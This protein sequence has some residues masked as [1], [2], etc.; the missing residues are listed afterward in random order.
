M[1]TLPLTD[2]LAPLQAPAEAG[3]LHPVTSPLEPGVTLVEASAGTGKTFS[4]VFILVRLLLEKR[5]ESVDRALVVTFTNAATDELVTRVRAGLRS[6]AQAYAGDLE[7]TGENQIWFDLCARYPDGRP[8]VETALASIDG[9]SVF[10]IHGFCKRV[11]EENAV[12]SGTPYGAAFVEDAHDLLECAALDWW[13]RTFYDDERLACLAVA[14]GWTPS[15]WLELF[16]RWRM[17]PET[18]IDPAPPS[19][20]AACDALDEVCAEVRAAW[21]EQRLAALL[22][23]VKWNKTAPLGSEPIEGMSAA[24]EALG[25]GELEAVGVLG[26]CT[27]GALREVGNK[28]KAESKEALAKLPGD[29]FCTACERIAPA[30]EQVRRALVGDFL[31]V[32][33]DEFEQE[34][35]RRQALGFDDLLRRLH[36]RITLEGAQGALAG[37]IRSRY[38]AAL[39]D[40]FQDTDPF[41]F[42]IFSIAFRDRPLFL[43]GDPKQAIYGFRGADIF[44]YADAVRQAQRRYTLPQNWRSTTGLVG[45][46]NRI[47]GRAPRGFLRHDDE[48]RF[49]NATAARP[50]P[51]P[52]GDGGEPLQWW[53]VP[54]DGDRKCG[55]GVARERLRSRTAAE[56]VALL[57]GCELTENGSTRPVRPADIA[58]LVRTHRE[59]AAMQQELQAARVPSIVAGMGD[60]L[61]S[62]ELCELERVLKAIALPLDGDA[63]RSALATELW[64]R[65]AE[66]IRALLED[67]GESEWTALADRLAAD[68]EDWV[69]R[70]FM[71]MVQRWM[72]RERVPERML[73]L[74][75]GDRRMTNLR[76]A[77]ELLHTAS[78]TERLSPDG[79]LAWIVRERAVK[80]TEANRRELR[81]ES[82]AEAVQIVTVHR[83]KG[84]EYGITFCLSLWDPKGGDDEDVL[85][86][87]GHGVVL[88]L[89]GDSWDERARRAESERTAEELRLA[90]VALTRAKWR[91]YVG[92]GFVTDAERSPLAWLLRAEAKETATTCE[93]LLDA[94]RAGLGEGGAWLERMTRLVESEPKLM[95]CEVLHGLSAPARWNP[96]ERARGAPPAAR[97]F[98]AGAQLVRLGMASFTSLTRRDA[99][100]EG[101]DIADPPGQAA[102]DTSAGPP[103]GI[104][105]LLKGR[106]TGDLLHAVFEHADHDAPRGAAARELVESLIRRDPG[107]AGLLTQ[108]DAADAIVEM[109]ARVTAAPLPGAGF[110]LADVP[111]G[112]T[113]REWPFMLPLAPVTGRTLA[114]AFAEHAATPALREY[115]KRLER[116]SPREVRGYLTGFVDFAFTRDGRWYLLD[117]KSNHL[118]N[119]AAQY[120]DGR[121]LAEMLDHH[122]VLQYHLYVLALHRYL[123][124]RVPGYSYARD[125]GGV[126]Y[127][128]VRG[129]GGAGGTGW[130]HDRPPVA[131]IEALD[132]ALVLNALHREVAS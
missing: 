27:A 25:R 39:I 53:F 36:D 76:H 120:D 32:V 61:H 18:L 129:I 81:L 105:A 69:R 24:V 29:P 60:I 70:G 46:V 131:L 100:E 74:A 21:N 83:S 19:I 13:R 57:D 126:W 56:I 87:E 65:S 66:D 124:T 111:R 86:H 114:R 68:R 3:D 54:A 91:C 7:R 28:Q 40:E 35:R 101:R 79:L 4:I 90:Y 11:L 10:T 82:D 127:A 99:V 96:R 128:F 37:A 16:K 59:A 95:R 6:A 64:G 33:A 26:G 41:Q 31:N 117:W 12:E 58:V 9:L 78:E 2:P 112:S 84:L 67:D 50:G 48:I 93:D 130:W 62:D 98:T 115:A 108:P 5:V 88:D 52:L 71:H 119:T 118:G 80:P 63:V 1:T 15:C 123:T 132:L 85:V 20:E 77:V 38:D 75:A 110:T 104:F 73:R 97:S 17:H 49:R 92:W 107:V 109:L 121:I 106:R 55:K 43:I 113:L 116:L 72:A 34:K 45:A 94:A 51:C 89:G 22:A 125:F 8:I 30:L 44:A 23:P 42:P 103:E 47:F 14:Q 102:A 122:Y